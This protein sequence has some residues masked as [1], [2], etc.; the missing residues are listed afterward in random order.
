MPVDW[1][2]G[3]FAKCP[4]LALFPSAV[5]LAYQIAPGYGFRVIPMFRLFPKTREEW[6]A[7][8]LFIFQSYVVVA[9]IVRRFFAS[10][11]ASTGRTICGVF[12][13][14]SMRRRGTE[15]CFV[16]LF[17]LTVA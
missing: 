11:F 8:F 15:T 17:F 7:A 9:S 12:L 6:F 5:G 13:L 3:K 16:L 10:Y 2:E 4:I 14:N 1:R